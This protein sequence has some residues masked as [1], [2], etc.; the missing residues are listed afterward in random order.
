LVTG[1][2]YVNLD[3]YPQKPARLVSIETEVKQ[4][5]TISSP[6]EELSR[7]IET[8]PLDEMANKILSTLEGIEEF[9]NSP[10]LGELL[11][12]L[13][14]AVKEAK[15]LLSEINH[16]V[17]PVSEDIK[18]TLGNAQKLLQ[19]IDN[20]IEPLTKS[21]QAVINDAGAVTQRLDKR[22]DPLLGAIEETFKTTRAA[23]SQ[24]NKTLSEIE[25][26]TGDGARLNRQVNQTLQELAAAA[27]SVRLLADYLERH[28]EALIRGKR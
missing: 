10:E 5:P 13:E 27:R 12:S 11:N 25:G 19:N 26:A 14:A 3:F 24:V 7:T 16:Q 2:L 17:Q 1:L 15:V 20:S 8:L 9:V 23:L 4:L 28:P 22:V 21:L 18:H 6:L